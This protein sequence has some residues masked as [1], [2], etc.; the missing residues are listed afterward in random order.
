MEQSAEEIV[1]TSDSRAVRMAFDERNAG[2]FRMILMLF[3]ALFF[4]SLIVRLARMQWM[5]AVDDWAMVALDA[6]LIYLLAETRAGRAA[7]FVRH[8][9]TAVR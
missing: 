1:A 4:I 2:Y 6:V 7:K 3:V 8:H 9:L 5:H